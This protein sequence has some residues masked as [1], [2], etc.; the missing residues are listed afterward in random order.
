MKIQKGDN[1]KILIGKNK[2]VTGKVEV[3][4]LAKGTVTIPGVNEYK[5]H[6]KSRTQGQKSEIITITKPLQAS[7]VALICPKCGKP[8][9]VGYSMNKAGKK[10]RI[11]RKCKKE[12]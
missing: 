5:K 2:G 11:C 12:I 8:T 6:V 4:D 1:V 3:V 10:V 7:K 9:R